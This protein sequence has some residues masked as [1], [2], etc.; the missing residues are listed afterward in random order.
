MLIDRMRK[1]LT[2]PQERRLLR[3]WQREAARNVRIVLHPGIVY[4]GDGDRHH[5]SASRLAQ[6]YGVPLGECI[7]IRN[8]KDRLGY[9][10]DDPDMNFVHLHPSSFGNYELPDMAKLWLETKN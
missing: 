9:N 10:F 3:K 1:T 5:V 4:A 6:L 8:A 2:L 7:V